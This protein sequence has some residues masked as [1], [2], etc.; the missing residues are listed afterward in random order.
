MLNG[1]R[2]LLIIS[3]GIAIQKT[4]ALIDLL[5]TGGASI[6]AIMTRGAQNFIAIDDIARLTGSKVHTDTFDKQGWMDHIDLS[7]NADLVLVAPATANLIAKM[8]YGIADDMATTT[9]LAANKPIM[10]CPAMN[11]EMWNAPATQRNIQTLRDDG[12]HIVGPAP[13]LLAC[14]EFGMGRLSEP[15]DIFKAVSD[16]FQNAP[17]PLI[18]LPKG[19]G[20]STPPNPPSPFGRGNE[21]EG[22]LHG[23]TAIV[24]SGPTYEAIDP[25]RF[26]ANRSSG[27]QGHAIAKALSDLGA[28]VTLITGPTNLSPPH[29]IETI[30]IESAAEMLESC[31]NS[32]PADIAVFAA[33]VADWTP[34]TYNPSKMKKTSDTAMTLN[35]KQNPD[36]LATLSAKGTMRPRLVVG[37]AAETDD[38]VTNAKAKLAKKGCDWI[39]ANSVNAENPVFSS[40]E[41][42]VYLITS[43]NT[44]EW[45]RAS[46]DDVARK[47][48]ER[49]A[50][51]FHKA[52]LCVEAEGVKRKNEK[53]EV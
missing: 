5:K 3:G 11:V 30:T 32:L 26:V 16:H 43:A 8:T 39:V 27:K 49:I 23:L 12:I 6:T 15:A 7:R 19:E 18:P 51:F 2:V 47:L 24:T 14:G 22:P 21:G 40:N 48:G 37:F 29:G 4:P 25:V 42:Q 50:Q 33:A 38:V 34:E 41:N 10:V 52:S 31:K 53:Q 46:K 20:N 9:L 44:E 1:K 28:S 36:I 35:L 13:G 17:S 45:P